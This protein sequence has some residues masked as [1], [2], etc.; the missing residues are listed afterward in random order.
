MS[1]VDQFEEYKKTDE[2]EEYRSA[3]LK[4]FPELFISQIDLS[5]LAWFNETRYKQY[6]EDNFIEWKSLLKEAENI[7][8]EKPLGGEVKSVSSYTQDEWNEKFGHLEP[9]KG[10]VAMIKEEDT[11]FVL[12][13]LTKE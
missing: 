2:Y 3:L 11:T 9:I 7:I 4:D 5:I 10:Q 13:D 12:P 8:I 1:L 6:C